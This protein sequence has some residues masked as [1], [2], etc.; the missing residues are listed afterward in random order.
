MSLT[1]QRIGMVDS[2]T[3][4]QWPIKEPL[5]CS[6]VILLKRFDSTTTTLLWYSSAPRMPLPLQ[7]TCILQPLADVNVLSL[8]SSTFN[9]TP[10]VS[11][12]YSHVSRTLT[13][14]QLATRRQIQHQQRAFASVTEWYVRCWQ[15][16]HPGSGWWLSLVYVVKYQGPYWLPYGRYFSGGKIFVSSE[17]LASSWKNICGHGILNHTWVLCGSVLWI[18]ISWFA[19][20]PQKPRKFYFPKIPAIWYL[21]DLMDLF[22][23]FDWSW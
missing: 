13:K 10:E 9:T 2:L 19:S 17:F 5:I 20:Q 3:L 15:V 22:K 18:K 21:R 6:T 7:W 1:H 4:P 14:E 8:L 16:F 12:P 11:L 23:E